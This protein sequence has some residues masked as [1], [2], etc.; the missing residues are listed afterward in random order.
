M[1]DLTSRCWWRTSRSQNILILV[2]KGLLYKVDEIQA[3]MWKFCRYFFMD[4]YIFL[5]LFLFLL[6]L[7]LVLGDSICKYPSVWYIPIHFVCVLGWMKLFVYTLLCIFC[8]VP[9]INLF[10]ILLDLH[11]P[12]VLNNVIFIIHLMTSV[13]LRVRSAFLYLLHTC[14]VTRTLMLQIPC[15]AFR[16]VKSRVLFK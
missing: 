5:F 12:Y 16:Y 13:M 2:I 9:F 6:L 4:Y 15:R 3:C 7:F 14:Q 10:K 1:D 8:Y 11:L